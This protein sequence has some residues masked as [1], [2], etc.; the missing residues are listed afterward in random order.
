MKPITFSDEPAEWSDLEWIYS[1]DA[2]HAATEF[3]KRPEQFRPDNLVFDRQIHLLRWICFADCFRSAHA[4][5]D[6]RHPP[7]PCPYDN[8]RHAQSLHYLWSRRT[9]TTRCSADRSSSA[10]RR[11]LPSLCRGEIDVR[12]DVFLG[13]NVTMA[14]LIK[15]EQDRVAKLIEKRRSVLVEE[16][17]KTLHLVECEVAVPDYLRTHHHPSVQTM[18]EFRHNIEGFLHSMPTWRVGEMVWVAER[19]PSRTSFSAAPV[20][21]SSP[22]YHKIENKSGPVARAH[23][24]LTSLKSARYSGPAYNRTCCFSTHRTRKQS[25]GACTFVTV[26]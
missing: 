9:R 3:F 19:L 21:V 2:V 26:V 24:L 15:R 8:A 12:K 17:L 14:G 11:D 10:S 1:N 7:Q 5:R 23:M 16:A 25:S 13:K 4:R 22:R 6:L 20:E 18:G